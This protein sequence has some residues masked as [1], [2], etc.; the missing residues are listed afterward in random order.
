MGS[1]SV[2]NSIFVFISLPPITSIAPSQVGAAP[3]VS[4]SSPIHVKQFCGEFC[5]ML[6]RE[7]YTTCGAYLKVEAF[8]Y[9]CGL[10]NGSIL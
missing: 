6:Q 5:K 9:G 2:Y 7:S 10:N 4:Q 1:N 3:G 8:F